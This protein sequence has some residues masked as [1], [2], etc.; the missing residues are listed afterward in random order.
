MRNSLRRQI[1]KELNSTE[2]LI[3]TNL[4]RELDGVD[5]NT[6]DPVQSQNICQKL[7]NWEQQSLYYRKN[8][9]A[10]KELYDHFQTGP[11]GDL[12]E[13]S[14][15]I[16]AMCSSGQSRQAAVAQAT[17]GQSAT[18]AG[19]SDAQPT[20]PA[21]TF[22]E[23]T[24][25]FKCTQPNAVMNFQNWVKA[26]AKT[27]QA[28]A[29]KADGSFG[30]KTF[31]AAKSLGNAV[32]NFAMYQTIEDFKDQTKLN[33]VCTALAGDARFRPAAKPATAAPAQVAKESVMRNS[34]RQ[35]IIKELNYLLEQVDVSNAAETADSE[36]GKTALAA[37]AG[38]LT[39]MAATSGGLSGIKGGPKTAK[40]KI[41][42]VV[43]AALAGWA[44]NAF[45]DKPELKDAILRAGTDPK[46]LADFIK[47]QL[48]SDYIADDES[49]AMV[50]LA[51]AYDAY[52]KQAEPN[53]N[54][55][56]KTIQNIPNYKS[57]I[58][59][60]WTTIMGSQK[61]DKL[62]LLRIMDEWAGWGAPTG[63]SPTPSPQPTPVPVPPPPKPKPKKKKKKGG[64]GD[65]GVCP[66]GT[67][68][69]GGDVS[70]CPPS[71][72]P[73]PNPEPKPEPSPKGTINL[74]SIPD[75][76]QFRFDQD[77]N[78]FLSDSGYDFNAKNFKGSTKFNGIRFAVREGMDMDEYNVYEGRGDKL[79]KI[80]IAKESGPTYSDS[81]KESKQFRH[82]KYYDSKKEKE[83]KV[84]F[85]RLMRKL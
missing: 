1:L 18:P 76:Y 10:D 6:F 53:K 60:D 45:S 24:K 35:K 43:G 26:N 71:P 73:P 37:A 14:R 23:R 5:L 64:G 83:A 36:L 12:W 30:P 20:T 13:K 72:V 4:T 42:T 48:A 67:S 15:Q 40:A 56:R 21:G 2:R 81:V 54:W 51:R 9:D 7:N 27:P 39:G 66:D 52:C 22:D 17:K 44:A 38:G 75:Q 58:N 46:G 80:G 19:Q 82:E 77:W 33:Q 41:A 16:K 25:S 63:D 11:G 69:P 65:K 31:A 32:L 59:S 62:E 78:K 47:A 50:R 55:C 34:L 74:D 70:K 68:A 85:E 28:K 3:I 84:L 49:Q 8:Q 79:V 29:I 57:A 61:N